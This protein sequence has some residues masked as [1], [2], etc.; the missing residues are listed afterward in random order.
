MGAVW[1]EED[2][3]LRTLTGALTGAQK[4]YCVGV[5]KKKTR[6]EKVLVG[7][8]LLLGCKASEPFR[9]LLSTTV[10]CWLGSAVQ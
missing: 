3:P 1:R 10:S 9:P 2:P 4:V 7:T 5:A 6:T 8:R